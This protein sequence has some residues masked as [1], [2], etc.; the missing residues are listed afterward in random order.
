M[1]DTNY[2]VNH[3]LAVKVWSRKLIHE[4]LKETW[5]NRFVG[6]DSNSVVQMKNDLEKGPGD[7][8]RVGLRM[9]LNGDGVLGDNTLEG[10]EESLTTYYDDLLIDQLRHAVRSR[11]KMSE[12][13]VPFSVRE[14]ARLGLTDW[15]SDRLDTMFFNQLTGNTNVSDLRYT[16]MNAT[17]APTSVIYG[18]SDVC[19]TAA[20]L[21]ASTTF[22]LS[23]HDFDRAV[24]LAKTRS[25]MIRPIKQGGDSYYVAFLHPFAVVRLVAQK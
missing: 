5:F 8:I 25:P 2:G 14:E 7:R 6:S 17:V 21:S 13:R 24:A 22:A 9:L 10:S 20:S 19:S 15:W 16:G 18:N 1:A 12:Q 11:G 4:A 23:L 3:P